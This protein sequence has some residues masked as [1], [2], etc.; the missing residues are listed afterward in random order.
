VT[1]GCTIRLAMLHQVVHNASTN[2]TL[3]RG[4]QN[5]VLPQLLPAGVGCLLLLTAACLHVYGESSSSQ[6]R[7]HP[8]L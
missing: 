5:V 3:H 6:C 7:H 4:S 2:K 1:D 8:K